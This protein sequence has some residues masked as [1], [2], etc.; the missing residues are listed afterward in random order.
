MMVL[1]LYG[2]LF[3]KGPGPSTLP[4]IS[5]VLRRQAN[6][7][8]SGLASMRLAPHHSSFQMLKTTYSPL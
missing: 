3:R 8:P 2:I 4:N 7:E 6:G 1:S 5:L